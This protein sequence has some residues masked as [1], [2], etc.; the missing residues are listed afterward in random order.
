MVA[1]LHFKGRE[2]PHPDVFTYG[3]HELDVTFVYRLV[4]YAGF[5]TFAWP[6]LPTNQGA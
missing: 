1:G 3:V 6:V 5:I 4:F 2:T